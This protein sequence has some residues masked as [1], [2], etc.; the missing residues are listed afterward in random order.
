MNKFAKVVSDV[1]RVK[2]HKISDKTSPAD[3]K[4]WD[5]FRGLLLVTEIEGAFQVK[6]SMEEI[7]SI[8]NIGDFKKILKKYNINP[9]E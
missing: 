2:P 7:L 5:S 9:D 6:F 3:V 1:L 4:N 8:K